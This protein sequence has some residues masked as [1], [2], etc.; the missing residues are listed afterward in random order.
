MNDNVFFIPKK[1]SF[2]DVLAKGLSVRYGNDLKDLLIILPNKISCRFLYESLLQ[3]NESSIQLPHIISLIGENDLNPF[4]N[5]S[6]YLNLDKPIDN[7]LFKITILQ[8]F[9]KWQNKQDLLLEHK[10]AIEEKSFCLDFL[11]L[12]ALLEEQE[13]TLRQ[14]LQKLDKSF[15]SLQGQLL[16]DFIDFFNNNWEGITQVK[17]NFSKLKLQ[18]KLIS[19]IKNY[20]KIIIAGVELDST[21][22]KEFFNEAVKANNILWVGEESD[23]GKI[24]SEKIGFAREG[25]KAILQS[26]N[27]YMEA[28]GIHRL[29][30]GNSNSKISLVTQNFALKNL[31]LFKQNKQIKFYKNSDIIKFLSLIDAFM[32]DKHKDISYLKINL[33]AGFSF[34][35]EKLFEEVSEIKKEKSYDLSFIKKLIEKLFS[36]SAVQEKYFS[37]ILYLSMNS[38]FNF[39]KA[40]SFLQVNEDSIFFEDTELLIIHPRD[41]R[42]K[43]LDN[44]VLGDISADNWAFKGHYLLD[45]HSFI[46]SFGNIA[47]DKNAK[48]SEYFINISYAK[49]LVMSFSNNLGAREK[50]CA[51]KELSENISEYGFN[52]NLDYQDISFTEKNI[53]I[54]PKKEDR[55]HNLSATEF[56]K[57][58]RNPYAIYAKYTLN[59]KY[60]NFCFK[61]EENKIFGIIVHKILELYV[62]SINHIDGDHF[63]FLQELYKKEI[64]KYFA[65][66]SSLKIFWSNRLENISK[67]IISLL[68]DKTQ[69]ILLPEYKNEISLEG[70]KIKARMDLVENDGDNISIIDYKTGSPPSAKNIKLGISVQMLV[71][72]MILKA[73]FAKNISALQYFVTKGETSKAIEIKNIVEHESLIEQAI[74][75]IP[76]LIKSYQAKD[77]ISFPNENLISEYDDYFHLCRKNK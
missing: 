52:E 60:R 51:F 71:E 17:Y 38:L 48:N 72:A 23:G 9:R 28:E 58:I 4:D 59:L 13:I 20:K 2:I 36:L 11:R 22:N 40:L 70:I 33:N 67:R 62:K 46:T 55:M 41:V 54:A 30:Q 35:T 19:E 44:V 76:K 29:L 77:I 74:D 32:M 56:E 15:F 26:S 42:L 75:N 37:K 43:H 27:I 65:L 39:R 3:N 47:E 21:A 61:E 8:I 49:N 25:F 69:S 14:L 34:A 5:F 45:N 66:R 7:D 57:M 1:D 12:F 73:I 18:A 10:K 53:I 31:V 50:F 24:W 64:G 6:E 68:A 63:L 16:L